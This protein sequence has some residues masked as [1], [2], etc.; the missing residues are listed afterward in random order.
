ML[1]LSRKSTK[2]K[3]TLK[4]SRSF[5]LKDIYAE[6]VSQNKDEKKKYHLFNYGYDFAKL[7]AALGKRRNLPPETLKD[8][9]EKIFGKEEFLNNP[10]IDL[11]FQIIAY[12]KEI[13][14]KPDNPDNYLILKEINKCREIGEAYC[15]AAF[16]TLKNALFKGEKEDV[17]F[18][19]VDLLKE[20]GLLIENID[21]YQ[22]DE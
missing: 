3:D 19:M 16:S 9:R 1:K 18:F 4:D 12:S 7:A 8:K 22:A 14:E 17:N 15:N 2:K 6:F 21:D 5:Y 20:E 11:V 10:D 13:S